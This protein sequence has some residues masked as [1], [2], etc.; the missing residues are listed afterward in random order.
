MRPGVTANKIAVRELDTKLARGTIGTIQPAGSSIPVA[1]L[2][3]PP[4][5]RSTTIGADQVKKKILAQ[6]QPMDRSLG[7]PI[8]E[9]RQLRRNCLLPVNTA[10]ST[11]TRL[12]VALAAAGR[13]QRTDCAPQLIPSAAQVP[14]L[15]SIRFGLRPFAL[16]RPL[17]SSDRA[18]RR[19][20]F[21]VLEWNAEVQRLARSQSSRTSPLSIVV[22]PRPFFPPTAVR[23][24][25]SLNRFAAVVNSNRIDLV[26]PAL[27]STL[28]NEHKPALALPLFARLELVFAFRLTS[29]AALPSPLDQ[30]ID[31]RTPAASSRPQPAPVRLQPASMLVLPS[32]AVPVGRIMWPMNVGWATVASGKFPQHE[33][34]RLSGE[35]TS[36]SSLRS[37]AGAV[38]IDRDQP[39]ALSLKSKRPMIALDLGF[40]TSRHEVAAANALPRRRGPK[41]PVVTASHHDLLVAGR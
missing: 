14:S 32:L 36:S 7:C 38:R 8:A 24:I 31:R 34:P 19:F 25:A 6:T 1:L 40:Q 12:K 23:H 9:V 17:I 10:W 5:R 33:Y 29:Q 2:K 28:I 26:S 30:P 4:V 16:K 41:L 27:L 35:S 18:A 20:S 39:A 37:M 13:L 11:P 21:K 22:L 3:L 15:F